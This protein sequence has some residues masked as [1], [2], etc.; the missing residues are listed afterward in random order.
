MN[1]LEDR[2]LNDF[3]RGFPLVSEPYDQIAMQLGHDVGGVLAA[4]ARLRFDGKVSRVGATYRP[5]AFGASTLAAMQV[6]ASRLDSVA[7]QVS[8][9]PEVNHN[10]QRDHVVNLWFVIAASDGNAL[11]QTIARIETSCA[12]PVMRLPLLAEYHIDLGFDLARRRSPRAVTCARPPARPLCLTAP[13]RVLL[14]ALGEGLPLAARPYALLGELCGMNESEVIDTLENWLSLGALRRI[15]VIVR[16]RELG[17]T[18]NAMVVWDVP[19]ETVDM[20]GMAAAGTGLV[21]LCYR[22]ARDPEAWPFNLYCMIHGG[23]RNL[24]K[25]TIDS[26]GQSCGLAHYSQQILFGLRRFKQQGARYAEAR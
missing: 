16:H 25:A 2:L 1:A 22:R 8:A 18:E 17:F 23:N 9:I 4:L 12:L 24:V 7:R 14:A 20:H 5:G 21:N 6:P 10:Y 15:G 26:L 11:I 19:D 3:Q 13:E